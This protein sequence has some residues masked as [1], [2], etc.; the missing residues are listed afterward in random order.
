M[1]NLKLPTDPNWANIAEKNLEEI[2]TDHAYCEQK[3]A[4]A[5]ISFMVR[6]PEKEDLVTE[7]IKLAQEELDHFKMVHDHIKARGLK[8][9]PERRDNYVNELRQF[10]NTGANKENILIYKLLLS[11]IIEAR[12]CER[13]KILS[14]NIND[15]EL[16]GFYRQLM[17][18]EA[19]HYTTFLAF[20]K[21]YGKDIMDVDKLWND[22][23]AFEAEV[24]K[25]YGKKE[26]IHG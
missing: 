24:V 9:G 15:T 26:H 21:K 4:S 17:I 12:S 3:A 5:A 6:Y 7:M 19:N 20:A 18:S 16:S 14:E 1:L 22:F 2:L 8:L 23:L 13:F 25:N 10:F 11:A